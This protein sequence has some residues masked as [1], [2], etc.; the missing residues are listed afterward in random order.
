MKTGFKDRDIATL[1]TKVNFW[2]SN[3]HKNSQEA[4]EDTTLAV[5]TH[6]VQNVAVK[7]GD[8]KRDIRF[9]I[10]RLA[11]LII[12]GSEEIGYAGH[13]EFG[14]TPHVIE[15]RTSNL[16]RF[17]DS[18]GNPVFA[19]RVNHPGTEAQPFMT[20]AAEAAHRTHKSN[21][22]AAVKKS[23]TGGTK[24][25]APRQRDERGRFI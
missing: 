24:A 12:A 8:L 15:P 14:T 23:K 11:G 18:S 4:V 17:K 7:R 13:V 20:P 1:K 21:M 5:H 3:V 2:V 22:K 10:G 19:R 9:K 16:L 25:T 6:A